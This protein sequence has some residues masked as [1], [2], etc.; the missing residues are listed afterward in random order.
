MQMPM[1]N[2]K[3]LVVALLADK[4]GVFAELAVDD[5]LSKMG[6]SDG[7]LPPQEFR[8]FM[9]ALHSVLPEDIDRKGLC[10]QVRRLLLEQ[11]GM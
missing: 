8:R 1:T 3:T 6:F 10:H 7:R 2:W 4:L 9:E 11:Y 5:A